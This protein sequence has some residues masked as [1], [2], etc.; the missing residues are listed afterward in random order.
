M[1]RNE[2]RG[3]DA[4]TLGSYLDQIRDDELLTAAEE[5][6][7]ARAVA[8]ASL[9]SVATLAGRTVEASADAEHVREQMLASGHRRL[10]VVDDGRLVGLLCLKRTGR[11]FCSDADVAART[12]SEVGGLP[13]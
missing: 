3:R 9:R 7:L 12:T 8:G 2:L 13:S 4:G 5:G 1:I 11:G 6:D 10:A